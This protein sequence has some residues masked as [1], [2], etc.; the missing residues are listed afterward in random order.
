MQWILDIFNGQIQSE[1]EDE[2]TEIL[3]QIKV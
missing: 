3:L 1:N 2:F